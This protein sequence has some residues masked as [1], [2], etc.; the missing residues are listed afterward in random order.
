MEFRKLMIKIGIIGSGSWSQALSK[1][2]IN[3]EITIKT[4]DLANAKNKFPRFLIIDSFKLLEGSDIIFFANSSQ[5]MRSV[6][7]KIPKSTKS[8]FVICNKGV[9]KKNK[10]ELNC[11]V[12]VDS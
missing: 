6:V 10:Y 4:R 2:L 11:K 5:S 7:K 12:F 3:C 8:K 9:E 1:I